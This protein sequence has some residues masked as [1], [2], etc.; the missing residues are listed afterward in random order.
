MDNQSELHM[1]QE[2][3]VIVIGAGI[4]GSA[5]AVQLAGMGHDTVLLDRKAFPRHKTCGEFMS[6]E[7]LE[8]LAY[9]GVDP[10]AFQ[11]EPSVMN[12]AKIIMPNGGEIDS[13]LP[14]QAWGISRYE[15][16]MMLHQQ[17]VE[18]GASI[19]SKAMVLDIVQL[20]DHSYRVSVRQGKE[21]VHYH[22]K[23]VIGAY[24]TPRPKFVQGVEIDAPLDSE[25]YV[26]VKSHYTGIK[27]E[28]RVELYFC[29]GGYVGIS[30]IEGGEKANVAALL[31]LKT[32][33]RIGKSVSEI[34][35]AAAQDNEKLFA[36]LN[37]GAPV[38]GTQVSIAPVRLSTVPEPWSIFPHI[39]DALMV[40]PPLCGDGMSVALRS[41]MICS[42]VTDR[43]LKSE[44]A[45]EEWQSEY[46]LEANHHFGKLLK[47]ANRI[48][49]LAF[50]KTN[51][52][53]PGAAKLFPS[54]ASYLVKATRL[55]EMGIHR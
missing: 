29:E 44:I 51:R 55:S 31:P 34:L 50:A 12:S 33:Q 52:L 42:A 16:D 25:V 8:M 26:G 17:A 23:S 32:V 22:A 40:I 36:R 41:S 38:P 3:D 13:A 6:P 54:L 48:Q 4:A 9:V 1:E 20:D 46:T 30:P 43:Y 5:C 37:A 15:L 18:A 49:K 19:V 14:G 24:G 53:Y 10:F 47:R 28:P 35:Q 27:T 7:T 11:V 45:Y 2:V 21:V 39:G